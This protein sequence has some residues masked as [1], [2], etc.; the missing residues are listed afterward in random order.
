MLR[1]L[2]KEEVDER[3]TRHEP[4]AITVQCLVYEGLLSMRGLLRQI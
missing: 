4:R 1:I 2:R 3:A